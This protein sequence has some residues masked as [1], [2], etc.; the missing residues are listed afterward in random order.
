MKG[1]QH[2]GQGQSSSPAG[3]E[4]LGELGI[5]CQASFPGRVAPKRG[6]LLNIFQSL[7]DTLN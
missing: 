7:K 5:S 2:L 3:P 1:F 4:Q 6:L